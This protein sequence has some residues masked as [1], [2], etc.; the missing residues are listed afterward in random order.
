MSR[1]V[2]RDDEQFRVVVGWDPP[3]Q[4]YFA[5]VHDLSKDEEDEIVLWQGTKPDELPTPN[6]VATTIK[7]WAQLS[8]EVFIALCW[9][10]EQNQA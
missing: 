1:H 5:H 7:E 9:D 3:L 6:V 4:T 10:K 8:D 2:V